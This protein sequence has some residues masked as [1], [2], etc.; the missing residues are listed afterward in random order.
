MRNIH[1]VDSP[2]TIRC[3]QIG[4]HHLSILPIS[5]VDPGQGPRIQVKHAQGL[6]IAD[7]HHPLRALGRVVLTH[8][9]RRGVAIGAHTRLSV[10]TRLWN[11]SHCLQTLLD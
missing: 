7:K 11:P 8:M 6:P 2:P 4:F 9:A 10:C 1:V 5:I 3:E